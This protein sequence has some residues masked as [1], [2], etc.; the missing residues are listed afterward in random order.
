MLHTNL[1]AFNL[2]ASHTSTF[3]KVQILPEYTW[4]DCRKYSWTENL[5]STIFINCLKRYHTPIQK[6]HS[7]LNALFSLQWIILEMCSCYLTFSLG[8]LY[9]EVTCIWYGKHLFIISFSTVAN[10][11][12]IKQK[13]G[14]EYLLDSISYFKRM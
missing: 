4:G 5:C 11:P 10:K 9:N 7:I 1:N 13:L 12:Y 8:F 2:V 14:V 3:S 6:F